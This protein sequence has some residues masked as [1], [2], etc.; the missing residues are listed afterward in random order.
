VCKGPGA[1]SFL[2]TNAVPLAAAQDYPLW[3]NGLI[4]IAAAIV[5]WLAATRLVRYV[6]AIAVQ[7]GVGEAFAGMLLLGGITSLPEI[8]NVATSS[9]IGNPALAIN[10]L[11]GSASINVLLLAILDAFF[12]R[13]A[14]TAVVAQPTTLLQATLSMLVLALVAIAITTGD[15]PILG[16]GV[17]SIA[18]FAASI[19]AFWLSATYEAHAPWTLRETEQPNGGGQTPNPSGGESL[20]PLSHLV[21][22]TCALA[23]VILVAGYCISQ[24]GDALAVQTG[25]GAGIVGFVLIGVSTSLPELST[26]AA[27]LRLAKYEMAIGEVL[28]TNFVNLSL[29]LLADAVFTGGPVVDEIGRFETASALLGVVLTGIMLVGLLERRNARVLRM[30]YDSIGVILAFSGGLVLLYSLR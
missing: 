18:V 20:R 28:G 22:S 15:L 1:G 10:N 4:F 30:G 6:N 5:I 24:T 29:I 27:A 13:A 3:L 26:L 11:L 12:G 17:W 16:L 23:A 21:A 19:G 25:L 2:S 7:T 9:W 14:L 8:A